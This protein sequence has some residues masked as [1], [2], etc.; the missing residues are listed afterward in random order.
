MINNS[1]I[2]KEELDKFDAI[3]EEWWNKTGKFKIL[4][5]INPVR[6]SYINNKIEEHFVTLDAINLKNLNIL[7]IGCGGGLVSSELANSYH[8][9]TGIDASNANINIAKS[10]ADKNNLKINY[11]CSTAEELVI[12]NMNQYDVIICLE[13]IE[14]VN[15]PKIFI[16]NLANLLKKDGMIILSTIN[17]TT[18]SYLLSI[19]M[20]E[21]ILGWVPKNTHDY[22]KFLKPSELTQLFGTTN[23]S[24][25]ELKGLSYNIINNLWKLSDEIDVNYFA[26]LIA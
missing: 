9:I 24:L 4:H 6:I 3:S 11:I 20:A 22:N 10:Y 26:Y 16:E 23:I 2:N 7:D 17:R 1:S 5:Q 8:N 21:Y 13:L 14:H 25:K 19:I 18:K 15:N 12:N